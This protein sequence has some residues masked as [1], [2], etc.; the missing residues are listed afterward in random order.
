MKYKTIITRLCLSQVQILLLLMLGL[1][2]TAISCKK[3]SDFQNNPNLPTVADPSSL[4][5]SIEVDAFANISADADLAG[6]YLVYTQSKAAS[7]YYSWTRS[8]F[9]YGAI[10]QVVKMEQEARRTGKLNYV[11]LGKFFRAYYMV[12]MT[13]SFGDIP[14]SQM[15]QSIENGN[16][17][18]GATKPAYDTQQSIFEGVLKDLQIAADSLSEDHGSLTG[19]IIYGGNINSWKK[20][21]NSYT[22]RVLMSLSHKQTVGS[23]NISHRFKEIIDH[24]DAYPVFQSNDDNGALPYYALADNRYPYF[25]DNSMKTDYYLDSTFVGLLQELKDP[26]LFI[27]GKPTP[28]ATGAGLPLDD[29]NAYGGLRGS[30]TLDYNTSKRGKGTASQINNRYA[31]DSINEPSLLMGYPELQFLIAEAAARKWISADPGT[32]YKNGVEAALQFSQYGH[33]NISGISYTAQDIAT[34]LASGELALQPGREIEQIIT[35]KYI[36][37][38]MQCGWWPFYE[39]RRTGF[40]HFDVNGG[41]VT[42]VVAGK[43]AVALRW[44]YPTDEYNNNAENL[45]EAIKRQYPNGDNINGKMWLLK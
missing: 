13:L 14:Y 16:F 2:L 26:R 29:F 37:W 22:L 41:G 9:N 4:L 7:Q 21:I 5:P 32:Y 45:E 17:E 24:P 15:M 43:P 19:D 38:F 20:L 31:Y 42:N 33:A 8:E 1:S 44:N 23:I 30:A 3:F 11:Y 34:Y 10:T 25:N 6:R 35:Q 12:D 36:S 27:Y 18:A 39:Q 28:G 40:P